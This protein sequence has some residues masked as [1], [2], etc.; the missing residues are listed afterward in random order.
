MAG[1]D[2]EAVKGVL[3]ETH[4]A[5]LRE[6]HGT[7]A[8]LGLGGGPVLDDVDAQRQL[9]EAVRMLDLSA[10]LESK[11]ANLKGEAL[12]LMARTIAGAKVEGFWKLFEDTFGD[13]PTPKP[14]DEDTDSSCLG[15]EE[16]PSDA[17]ESGKLDEA[18]GGTPAPSP[19]KRQGSS[20]APP[21]GPPVKHSRKS[22]KPTRV[23]P[24]FKV[25][26]SGCTLERATG[27]F[28][29][30]AEEISCAGVP[31]NLIPP[32]EK[33]ADGQSVYY[34]LMDCAYSSSNRSAMVNHLRREH[35]TIALQCH[36]CGHRSWAAKTWTKH[37]KEHHPLSE[38]YPTI[39]VEAVDEADAAEVAA[40]IADLV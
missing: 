18:A 30:A 21:A 23:V 33:G 20:L 22:K 27:Y 1:L 4:G 2:I 17:S 25:V 3:E 36:V 16:L 31:N 29:N 32:R 35:L 9:L 26:V 5:F 37:F 34:C 39:K 11:A 12:S 24:V 8:T 19:A 7:L 28:P 10:R 14:S 13:P 38:L 6:T 40:S 15:S